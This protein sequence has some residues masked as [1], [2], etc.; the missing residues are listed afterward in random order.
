MRT[1]YKN[2][3]PSNKKQDSFNT[4]ELNKIKKKY[5]NFGQPKLYE[6]KLYPFKIFI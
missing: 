6:L 3:L 1:I 5:Q 4:I 2:S